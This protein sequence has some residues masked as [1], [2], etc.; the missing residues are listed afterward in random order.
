[1]LD[2]DL[3]HLPASFCHRR[4]PAAKLHAQPEVQTLYTALNVH[5]YGFPS[6]LLKLLRLRRL[7][8]AGAELNQ[9]LSLTAQAPT[10][11][12]W[13]STPPVP[14]VNVPFTQVTPALIHGACAILNHSSR[15]ISF[16]F[17]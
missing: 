8:D 11:L 7:R 15:C 3:R 17:I 9:S 14:S 4:H 10:F 6:V 13:F 16:S 2:R 1:M 5:I 12:G